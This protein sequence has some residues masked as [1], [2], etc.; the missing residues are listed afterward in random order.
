MKK[1]NM[2]FRPDI[3]TEQ[4][5]HS[6]WQSAILMTILAHNFW[7]QQEIQRKWA[8]H[9]VSVG[10]VERKKRSSEKTVKNGYEELHR[11]WWSTNVSWAWNPFQYLQNFAKMTII[12]PKPF[13][14]TNVLRRHGVC[15]AV[16]YR[17][18]W[19]TIWHR[20]CNAVTELTGIHWS[21]YTGMHRSV[22]T[23]LW[24]TK[25]MILRQNC[26]HKYAP[27]C[28]RKTESWQSGNLRVTKHKQCFTK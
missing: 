12:N 28:T 25:V 21:L 6:L 3:F 23:I 5:Q 24:C 10:H 9:S 8:D 1:S 20:L 18:L 7:T 16:Q 2:G 27:L 26:M 14:L 15:S 11:W 4:C 19:D 17:R 22:C 13:V